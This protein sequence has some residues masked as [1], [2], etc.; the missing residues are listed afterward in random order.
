MSGHRPAARAPGRIPTAWTRALPDI[1]TGPILTTPRDAAHSRRTLLTRGP[2]DH[3]HR[4]GGRAAQRLGHRLAPWLLLVLAWASQLVIAAG[5]PEP[6]SRVLRQHK[7]AEPDLSLYLREVTEPRARLAVNADEP[8]IPASTIKLLTTIAAL[9][10]LGPTYRWYTR[11]YLDGRLVDGQLDGDLVIQG[12]GDPSLATEDLWR[13]LWEI[14]ARGLTRITGDLVID[15]SA[16]APPGTSRDAF[17]GAGGSPYN[18][19]PVAF[20][21]NDQVTRVELTPEAAGRGLTAYLMPPLDRVSLVNQIRLVD[22]P[23]RSKNHRLGLI[24]TDG[25]TDTTLKL[26]GTFA[27][28]CGEDRI[29]RLVLDPLRHAGEAT[30]AIWRGLGGQIDGSIR[31]GRVPN[32]A[33]PFHVLASDELALVVRDINKRSNN[34]MTRTLFLTL[35]LERFGR[36]ATLEN[37]RRAIRD[38]LETRELDL[39]ELVIDNGSG[40]SRETRISARGLARLLEWVYANPEMSELSASL[41]ILGVDG[42]LKRRLRREQVQG[43]AHLKTGTLRGATGVAGFLDDSKGRRWILVSLINNPRLQGW[44][45]KAVENT[46]L[47]WLYDGADGLP[48]AH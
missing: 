33:E 35:G 40:L 15:N 45:G 8:R 16:I 13:F 34:L 12:G 19:L 46:L 18:A 29:E 1:L 20:T 6:I 21:V 36:P 3:P 10:S 27:T 28:G 24:R 9:D 17:D 32:G 37:G 25:E 22:A 42:T 31:E 26:T 48:D 2:T 44:R 47:R 38:W 4:P 7:L 43:S 41:P 5:L 39:G 30:A 14:R 11:A 23:C